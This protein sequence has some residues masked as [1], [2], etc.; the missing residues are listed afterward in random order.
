MQNQVRDFAQRVRGGLL[1]F[2]PETTLFFL[3]G[4]LNDASLPASTSISNLE[5]EVRILHELG[6]KFIMI[7]LMPTRLSPGS[8]P[9]R[10]LNKGITTIPRRLKSSMPEVHIVVSRWGGYYDAVFRNPGKYGIT[11]TTDH[12]AGRALSGED[13]TPC[14]S[15]D[16]YFF[17]HEGHPS[18]A[19]HRIVGLDLVLEVR[20]DFPQ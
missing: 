5:S 15:P 3:A 6:A 8:K 1:T 7:A 17:F 11:N 18:T 10:T 2:N 19:V 13:P 9:Y 12:C 4:G 20:R 14:A 16:S